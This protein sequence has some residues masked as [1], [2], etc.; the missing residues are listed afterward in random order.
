MGD[1]IMRLYMK[2]LRQN[3]NNFL[4]AGRNLLETKKLPVV[5][6]ELFIYYLVIRLYNSSSLGV[7]TISIR[8]F[9]ARASSV[10][11]ASIG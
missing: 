4:G 2:A 8:L 9:F 10:P 11:L 7:S 6:R 5:I 3:S 1:A